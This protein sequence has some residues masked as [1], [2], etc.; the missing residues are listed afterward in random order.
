M[1]G[2]IY[3]DSDLDITGGL[4]LSSVPNSTGSIVTWNAS[5]KVF[6]LRTNA[7]IIAD[8][9]L[10]RTLTPGSH[11]NIT[12]NSVSA[13]LTDGVWL[14]DSAGNRRIHVGSV[15]T[16][17]DFL[18][19]SRHTGAVEFKWQDAA[20]ASFM[21]INGTTL[22]VQGLGGT[23]SSIINADS[24]GSLFRTGIDPS[25][26]A[27]QGGTYPN[28]TVG[29]ATIAT[30]AVKLQTARTIN[31]TSFDGSANI[32]TARW[33]TARNITI[34]NTTKSVNGSANVSWSLAEIGIPNVTG[35]ITNVTQG[36]NQ[37]RV[38]SRQGASNLTFASIP[39]IDIR[40]TA[41][42]L[43]SDGSPGYLPLSTDASINQS[44]T[45]IF[46]YRTGSLVWQSSLMMKGWAG[47][48]GAWMISGNA[49]NSGAFKDQYYLNSTEPSTGVWGTPLEIIHSG[50][51][52]TFVNTLLGN[53]LPL[54]GGTMTGAINSTSNQILRYSGAV[55]LTM[56]SAVTNLVG[57]GTINLRP[58]NVSDVANQ[59]TITSMGQINTAN[60]GNSS[61]WKQAYDWGNFR[62]YGLGNNVA[63]GVGN[64]DLTTDYSGFISETGH[65]IPGWSAGRAWGFKTAYG[66]GT[67]GT[68][69]SMRNGRIV[70]KTLENTVDSGWIEIVH[71]N[72]LDSKTSALGFIKSNALPT[73]NVTTNTQQVVS[74]KKQWN[75]AQTF[76]QSNFRV[77]NNI[78]VVTGPSGATADNYFLVNIGDP[79]PGV[80]WEAEVEI[81]QYTSSN[82][83][84][85]LYAEPSAFKITG[86]NSAA[87]TTFVNR[88]CVQTKGNTTLIEN[89]TIFRDS[90]NV[91][92]I[93]FKQS[94]SWSYPKVYLKKLTLH[95]NVNDT[96]E[97]A[98]V[99]NANVTYTTDVSTLTPILVIPNSEI[100][101][102]SYSSTSVLLDPSYK[103]STGLI[104][105]FNQVFNNSVG[106]VSSSSLNS[107][108]S[109][110]GFAFNMAIQSGGGHGFTLF[111][112]IISEDALFYRKRLG[113]SN[114]ANYQVA[115][116]E[117]ADNKFALASWGR[118]LRV[119]DNGVII[120]NDTTID[121]NLIRNASMYS[122]GINKPSSG[123]G[124][125]VN[126]TPYSSSGNH[127]GFDLYMAASADRF[128]IRR[129]TAA[130]KQSW[131]E[132]IHEG[133]LDSQAT[134]LGFIKSSSLSGYVPTA[135]TITA[136]NGLTGGGN[137]TANRTITLGT[138]SAITLSS[139][140]S[141]TTSSHTHAFTPGGTTA[142]YIRGDGSLATMPTFTD[143][144][145]T[146]SRNGV[147]IPI[148]SQNVDIPVFSTSGA[149]L[150]PARVGSVATKYLR[151]DGTWVTPTN[152]TYSN[153]AIAELN[154]G[155][156]AT[157][158]VISASVL[159]QWLNAKGFS[160]Q[161]LGNSTSNLIVSNT[162]QRAALT[163]DVTAAQNSNATTIANSAVT[164]A[165]YQNI[166]TQRIL[167][168]G[169]AGTGNVQE[170]TLGANLS[171]STSGV[172]SATNTN[173]TY[174][175]GTGIS[176]S[177]TT[178]G[179]TIT[180][181]GTGT[182][183]QSITQTAN[184][185]Q[186]NLGTPSGGTSGIGRIFTD[187]SAYSGPADQT[188]LYFNFHEYWGFPPAFAEENQ[189]G[190]ATAK[191]T[192]DQL[193][194][195]A[196]YDSVQT[197]V[198]E[199]KELDVSLN[200]YHI[201]NVLLMSGTGSD[202]V[203]LED[204]VYAG[205]QVNITTSPNSQI[206]IY[207][208]N[209]IAT[210]G[211]EVWTFVNLVWDCEQVGW[212]ITGYGTP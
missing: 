137:L 177:G 81:H 15:S 150:V 68:A 54:S 195:F 21:E 76:V 209:L 194:F 48:Y 179:Q 72:N 151:E 156:V 181:N 205:D 6:G 55:R 27:L 100:D 97:N 144:I 157:G 10:Q 31:G 178:F 207:A 172:L 103:N 80:M 210:V 24:S 39:V 132:V 25:N 163:G 142:Q 166:A 175:A 180:T 20:G 211:N 23:G 117:W 38:F 138:P 192:A 190:N 11:I 57:G 168:R 92:I 176:L 197:I 34:G 212:V 33:G 93:G 201:T 208:N 51:Y 115:S 87:G 193:D 131:I 69:I 37:G 106:Y 147:N 159:N 22:R 49:H 161:T 89:I 145:T 160:T 136:G 139:T 16:T 42:G 28:M 78:A 203:T 153:M 60:H 2:T 41:S 101:K 158:R 104:G 191:A 198:W 128:F 146:I 122:R 7:Q 1:A 118:G 114:G 188:S 77:I 111:G 149:G 204:G 66:N 75:S 36:S 133:N 91:I 83:F 79:L 99:A 185:F 202:T 4:K 206:V 148:V 164:H 167:G 18:F 126:F 108:S 124:S 74:A 165:K 65:G 46:H 116:R 196:S 50:N 170:L 53:Y 120:H 171:L 110:A 200:G 19:R 13:I 134:S 96:R 129:E 70:F 121:T 174:S 173:T 3:H 63:A 182:F 135:R 127:Y 67:F 113:G 186:V 94:Q 85:A 44:L 187:N 56:D 43:G 109:Q 82:T 45:P 189:P 130:V 98:I 162:V 88:S 47:N 107:P 143:A 112:D 86:Y 183:V 90:S 105:D 84:N 35:L 9:G 30:N 184:G 140:N 141:V 71:D 155:T 32:I 5:T 59:V 58:N 26:I 52:S 62:D 29:I 95:H 17:N 8:L 12:S 40:S 73:N 64:W 61:Q 119:D 125:V 14:E 123:N 102:A 152:T 154:T 199:E 169:A